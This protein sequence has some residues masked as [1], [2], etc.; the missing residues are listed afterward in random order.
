MFQPSERVRV[1]AGLKDFLLAQRKG[2]G[3]IDLGAPHFVGFSE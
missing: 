2:R 1:G 3:T